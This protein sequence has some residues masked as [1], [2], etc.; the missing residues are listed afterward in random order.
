VGAEVAA[1]ARAAGVEV[2]IVEGRD[3]LLGGALPEAVGDVVA[4]W[5]RQAGTTV[6]TGR[7]AESLSVG[8]AGVEVSLADGTCISAE[9]ALIGF[10]SVLDR[11]PLRGLPHGPEGIHCDSGGR[12][13]GLDHMYAA[14]DAAAWSDLLT[15]DVMRNEHWSSASDQ[16]TWVAYTMMGLPPPDHL[17][18][19]APYFWSDQ[20][21]HKIQVLGRPALADR[22]GWIKHEQGARVVFGHWAGDRLVGVVTLGSPRLLV[23]YRKQI[24]LDLMASV[25]S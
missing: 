6:L 16:G 10:G 7:F 22:S 21:G 15:G 11:A 8:N 25:D 9:H 2:A 17:V 12:I 19:Y 18:A 4:G 1:T 20:H 23:P 13:D 5:H 24:A 14:G 3:S